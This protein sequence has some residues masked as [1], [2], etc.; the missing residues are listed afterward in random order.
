MDKNQI[1]ELVQ[2]LRAIHD[3]DF[4]SIEINGIGLCNGVKPLRLKELPDWYNKREDYLKEWDEFSGEITYPVRGGGDAYDRA[5]ASDTMYEGAYGCA[6]RRL[7][8]YLA[9]RIE[10]DY[11]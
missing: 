6:R 7:A 2:N 5:Q 9:K 8:G 1:Q 4:S 3:G 10:E 11:L